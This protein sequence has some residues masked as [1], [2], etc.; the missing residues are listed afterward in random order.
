MDGRALHFRLA[1]INN[2]NF[3][4][5]DDETGSWW[6]QVTGE[7]IFGPLAGRR[8]ERMPWDEVTWSLWKSEHPATQ[9]LEPVEAFEARYAKAGWEERIAKYPVPVDPPPEDP[10]QPRDL[11]VGIEEGGQAKAFPWTAL[12]EHR[13]ILDVVGGVPLALALHPDGRSLRCFRREGGRGSL[14]LF[15]TP[16]ADAPRL[17]DGDTG[18]AWDFAGRPVSG[19]PDGKTLEPMACLKDFWFDWKAYHSGSSVWRQP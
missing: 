4:M 6:Q 14:A 2:Q 12:A 3:I 10:L 1:G 13:L 7:A 15:L 18:M 16:D 17:V 8:L 9:V 19:P 11:V 5:R